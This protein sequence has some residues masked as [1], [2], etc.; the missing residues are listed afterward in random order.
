MLLKQLLRRIAILVKWIVVGVLCV[1]LLSFLVVTATNFI[2]YGHAREGSR[3]VYD[4]Y[5]LFLQS[6]GVR[7]TANNSVS[8]A[9]KEN[10]S[11]W[12]FGG[13]TMR[14]ATDFDERTIPS[15]LSEY[16]NS[17]REGLHFS[18]TNFG[19]NSFNSLLETKYLQKLLIESASAPDIIVFY[20]GANDAKYFLEHR[21]AYGHHGYRRTRAL[22]ESY[23]H[24]WFGLLKPLNAA[25][26]ASFS[27]ELY[28]RINQIGT[29]LDPGLPEFQTMIALNEGR[30]E[31]VNKISGC[32]GAKFILFWQPMLWVEE[33]QIPSAVKEQ[34]KNLVVAAERFETMR[35]NFDVAYTSLADR[36]AAKPYFVSLRGVFCDRKVP[37]YQADGVHLNDDGR[38]IV[39]GAIGKVLE[40]RFFK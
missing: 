15:F 12:M 29:P 3:A 16:L 33:C 39:A 34:E 5:T 1:E 13:S 38:R 35:R 8:K 20:D 25:L 28:D 4:P 22:I 18:V 23:Y 36:L 31:F 6:S 26:Y 30:Y 10:R 2:L 7:P 21:S 9:G 11:V 32:Y 27:K 24:S 19:T 40:Q 17:K 37:V 14:G